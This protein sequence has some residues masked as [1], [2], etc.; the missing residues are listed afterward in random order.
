MSTT[1]GSHHLPMPPPLRPARLDR[2]R[3]YAQEYRH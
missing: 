1:P 2:E 3:G